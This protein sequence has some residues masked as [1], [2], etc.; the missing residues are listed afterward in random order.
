LR[1]VASRCVSGSVSVC[2]ADRIGDW[3]ISTPLPGCGAVQTCRH[4]GICLF[5][6]VCL[7]AGFLRTAAID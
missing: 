3:A 1:C 6:V 7:V 2:G 4:C 5:C